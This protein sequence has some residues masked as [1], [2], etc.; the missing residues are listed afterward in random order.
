MTLFASYK[1]DWYIFKRFFP[2]YIAYK[3]KS[4]LLPVFDFYSKR[5]KLSWDWIILI[6]KS[7]Q[8]ISVHRTIQILQSFDL[9]TV[10]PN[11]CFEACPH[12]FYYIFWTS[13]FCHE[14]TLS[15][16]SA[17]EVGCVI[18]LMH[19]LRSRNTQVYAKKW[20]M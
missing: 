5:N 20:K 8:V 7:L 2:L 9:N 15:C 19:H 16:S 11:F 3:K 10:F 4:A 12:F 14:G 6:K 18:S 13:V 17:E 1:W